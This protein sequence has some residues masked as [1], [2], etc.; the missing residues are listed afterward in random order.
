MLFVM[1]PI[2]LFD[3]KTKI[4]ATLGPASSSQAVLTAMIVNGAD[5]IRLNASHGADPQDMRQK[6]QLIR[7]IS[8]SLNKPVAIFLDLQGPKIRVGKFVDNTITLQTGDTFVLTTDPIVGTQQKVSVS[9]AHFAQDVQIGE[10]LFID[11]GKVRLVVVDKHHQDVICNVTRGGDV[12]NNKGMNLPDT[13]IR[14]SAMTAK[15]KKDVHVAI[16]NQ[17]DYIALSIVSTAADV[18]ELR[19]Y[20]D[21]LGGQ[22]IGIISKIE[23][24]KAIDN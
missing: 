7:H 4:I 11:D 12:S 13:V 14:M 17:L 16:D 21:G 20:M 10:S 2:Q 3:R 5:V 6:I 24:Q 22:S 15:D 23:R 9:Y 19:A 8:Q 18:T 1:I